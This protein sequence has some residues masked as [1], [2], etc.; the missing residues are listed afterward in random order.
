MCL[1]AF[2]TFV[3][4]AEPSALLPARE[5]MA[6]SLGSHIVL[7][8]F[9]V[10]FPL[11][12]YVVHRR[13]IKHNDDVA[14]G[15]AKRWSK[16]AAV[17]FAVGAVSGTILSFE[18]GILWPEFMRKWGDVIGLPFALEGIAFFLEAIFIGI[19]LYGW[20]R[21]PPKVHV[22][23]LI[24]VSVAG[25]FGTFCILCVNSWMN[26]P[27]GF[28]YING[29]VTNVHPLAAMFNH[30]VWYMSIHMYLATFLVAGFGTASV[31][32]WGMLKGRTDHHHRLGFMI[33]F[34]FAAYASILQ[35]ISGHV[36]GLRLATDQPAKLAAMEMD[37]TTE[38]APSPLIVGGVLIDGKRRYSVPIPVL[39]SLIAR[40][41]LTKPVHGLDEFAVDARPKN[42]LV[43]V[44]HWAFQGMV[45][46]GTA[47]ALFALFFYGAYRKGHDLLSKRWFLWLGLAAGP[48]AGVA[49]ELGWITTEVGRQP[50]IVQGYMNIEQAV[51]GAGNLWWSFGILVSVYVLMGT[52]AV[53]VLRSMARR[54][55]NGESLDL[56]TPYGPQGHNG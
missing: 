54:W 21:L 37:T 6:I 20:D 41:S 12:I 28:D 3:L 8:C 44:V 29:K 26:A 50:W 9:G 15:L 11:M 36:S 51:T 38:K 53:L 25:A 49:L 39:G 30:A 1:V 13:G 45:G 32:A 27:S 24:P 16:V 31:Y 56:A 14:I 10:A 42:S 47:L 5:Q 55:R 22:S 40:S 52:G 7:S 34:V 4:A 33:P 19:Y 17:L 2:N 18:F 35:P 46:I 23:M 43:N 48:L